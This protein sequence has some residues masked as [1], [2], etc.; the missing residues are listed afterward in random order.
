MW[1]GGKDSTASVI[2]LHEHEDELL[3][4]GDEVIILFIEVMFDLKNNV[5]GHNPEV[6]SYIYDTKK[7]FESWGYEVNILRASTDYLTLFHGKLDGCPDPKRNGML[8]GFPLGRGMCWVKRELKDNPRKAYMKS[9][10]GTDYIEYVGMAFDELDRYNSLKVRNPK[11]DSLLVKY[12][13]TEEDARALCKEHKILSPQYSFN[14]GQKRDG[15][16]LSL[17][18][19]L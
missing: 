9:L 5:S 6:I 18:E 8:R 7:L 13:F 12:R 10:K 1:S 15:L 19:R 11:A 2:L 3:N 17:F 16:V 14:Y 4:P